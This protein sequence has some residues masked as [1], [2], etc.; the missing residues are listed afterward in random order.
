MSCLPTPLSKPSLCLQMT[1]YFMYPAI[2]VVMA[3]LFLGEKA[4]WMSVAGC[5]ISLIGVAF[6]A[7]PPFLFG[8]SV[9]HNSDHWIGTLLQPGCLHD[10]PLARSCSTTVVGFSQ[11]NQL[12]VVNCSQ[13]AVAISSQSMQLIKL[14]CQSDQASMGFW[15]I[16]K[17]CFVNSVLSTWMHPLSAHVPGAMQAACTSVCC[18]HYCLLPL[19]NCS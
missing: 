12:L 1:L 8:T 2:T 7:R 17:C 19:S 10:L 6:I 9:I 14:S 11:C 13:V 3:Y 18:Q 4:T 16:L 15:A 5:G